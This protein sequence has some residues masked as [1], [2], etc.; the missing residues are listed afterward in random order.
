VNSAGGLTVG[1]T[2]KK[3][4][5]PAGQLQ[6]TEAAADAPDVLTGELFSG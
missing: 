4:A 3:L 6:Q 5:I 2:L 1:V